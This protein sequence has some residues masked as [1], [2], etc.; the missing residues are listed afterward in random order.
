MIVPGFVPGIFSVPDNDRSRSRVDITPL[1]A[2]N[3]FLPHGCRD[4]EANDAANGDE[5][6]TVALDVA[7]DRIKFVPGWPAFESAGSV[8]ANGAPIQIEMQPPTIARL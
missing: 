1:D 6:P 7:D 5:L 4:S 3:L 8:C 2:A